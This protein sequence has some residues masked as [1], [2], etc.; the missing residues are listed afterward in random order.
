[1]KNVTAAVIRYKNKV[2]I[3]Q[4][5][6]EKSCANLWEFPGGKQ[7]QGESLEACLHREI[8]EELG[9]QIRICCRLGEVQN[10]NLCLH[11]YLCVPTAGKLE[12]H[13]HTD[14]HL[15]DRK[16]LSLYQFCPLDAVF[17]SDRAH[18]EAVFQPFRRLFIALPLPLS[19]T[20]Q[21]AEIQQ[22]WRDR[23]VQGKYIPVDQLHITLSFIGESL[24]K[25]AV[26]SALQK[27]QKT[28][29]R[30]DLSAAGHFKDLYYAAVLEN[31]ALE[32]LSTEIRK[33]LHQA[34]VAA[35]DKPFKGHVTLLRRGKI[36]AGVSLPFFPVSWTAK[37]II[38]YESAF[39]PGGVTYHPLWIQ[40]I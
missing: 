23:G 22:M 35:D 25:E 7:E 40:N 2:L 19:V 20:E 24:Q 11:L 39:I 31:P 30:I 26:I 13:A 37:E 10:Q 12:L 33:L 8:Q 34:G 4:R 29:F 5:P 28:A 27:V 9:I 3:C 6:V 32:Q 16:E 38:L 15:A 17:L 14:S 18:L 21:L 36:P 1:M